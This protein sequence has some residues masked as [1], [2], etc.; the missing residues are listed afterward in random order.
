VALQ[1]ATHAGWRSV[2]RAR[3][4]RFG[5]FALRVARLRPGSA[6]AR[7]R[8]AGDRTNAGATLALGRANV[9]RTAVASWYG[10]GF[11]GRLL[12]CGGRLGTAQLGVAHKTL[13]CGTKVTVRY[14]GRSIGVRVIDR[15]PYIAG[16]EFDLTAATA[17]ALRFSGFGPVLVTQ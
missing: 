8:F 13:P 5:R 4:D 7:L 11:Y 2:T 6:P 10:P 1:V 3:T 15:G 12:G 14:R 16:R 17:R 9:Y